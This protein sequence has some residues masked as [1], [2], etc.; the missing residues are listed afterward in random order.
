MTLQKFNFAAGKLIT[1]LFPPAVNFCSKRKPH[2]T[3]ASGPVGLHIHIYPPLS[4]PTHH[5]SPLPRPLQTT[6][7]TKPPS[8]GPIRV[9]RQRGHPTSGG[10]RGTSGRR[11]SYTSRD[12]RGD[13]SYN[14]TI[15]GTGRRWCDLLSFLYANHP[16]IFLSS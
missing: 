15:D 4:S 1:V 12:S 10:R 6:N 5:P 9:D 8:T 16:D 13:L 3:Q 14:S 11:R 7:C 2:I